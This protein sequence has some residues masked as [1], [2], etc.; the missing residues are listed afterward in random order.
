MADAA[1]GR[2]RPPILWSVVAEPQRHAMTDEPAD[3]AMP[4][5]P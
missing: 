4:L 2:S 5:S 3:R 1:A